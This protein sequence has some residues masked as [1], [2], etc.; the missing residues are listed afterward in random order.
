MSLINYKV[1]LKLKWIQHCVVSAVGNDNTDDNPNNAIF[2]I[3]DTKFYVPVVTILAKYN[4]K[5]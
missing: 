1:E 3:K 2:T 4:Q 5:L